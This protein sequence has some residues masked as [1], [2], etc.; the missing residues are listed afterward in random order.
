MAHLLIIELPGGNDSDILEAALARDDSFTFLSADLDH[1]MR[2]PV[3]KSFLNQAHARIEIS[4][5]TYTELER[6]VLVLHEDYP[7]DAVIC[8]IDT[9]IPEAARLADKLKLRHLNPISA[10][11]MRDKYLVRQRLAE[12]GIP[13]PLFELAR[14][15]QELA[16][17][18]ARIGLPVLI[19]PTDGFGSQNIVALSYP[20]DLDPY[21]TPLNDLLPTYTDY[22]LGVLANDRMLVE[23]RMSGTIIGCDTISENGKH[24]LLGLNEKLFFEDP[25][26]AIKGGVFLPNRPEFKVIESYVISLLD[27]VG[28]DWGAAHTELILT[29]E[30]PR[31]IEINPR[32]VGAKIPRLIGYA[33]NR[34]LYTDLIQSYLG[35][36]VS[37]SAIDT[38]VVA[39]TRWIVASEE[40]LL[41]HIELPQ[42]EDSRIRCVEIL[43]QPGD[44][45]RPPLDNADRIGYVMV[46]ASNR[47]EAEELAEW[48][49]SQSVCHLLSEQMQLRHDELVIRE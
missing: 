12:H 27:A 16:H 46:C 39:V 36:G 17:A 32:L 19:K 14:S 47:K 3:I 8:L 41:D 5:F 29:D 31:L 13:Q 43:K 28:F 10:A 1:Y 45:V 26:F 2:Q 35:Q 40:G 18:V 44:F 38:D 7:V 24:T 37:D 6:K 34:S 23:R 30:G 25:S 15:N 22:G 20:E 9:R 33:L 21:L 49:V 48:F 11:L 42:T 4:P